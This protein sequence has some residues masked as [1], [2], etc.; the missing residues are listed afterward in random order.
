MLRMEDIWP[1]D[2]AFV[3]ETLVPPGGDAERV[4]RV[5]REQADFLEALLDDPRLY[6]RLR[7]EERLVT[8]SPYL[9][10]HVIL[11]QVRRDV[12]R[13]PHVRE[14][15]DEGERVPVF[16]VEP[17]RAV[18]SDEAL[19]DYVVDLL[20]SYTKV[21]SG[22]VWY[23]EAGRL[24]RLRYSELDIPS[25]RRLAALVPPAERPTV[26]RRVGDGSLFLAGVFPDHVAGGR[27]RRRTGMTLTSLE[28]EAHEAYQQAAR[29][30]TRL[31]QGGA[32]TLERVAAH[33][34]TLRRLLNVVAD[35][36]LREHRAHWFEG[37]RASS[38]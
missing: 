19:R 31:G 6:Q 33:V 11:R 4:A 15:T 7:E 1:S 3:V 25:L 9:V 38:E 28:H 30:A 29:L 37:P 2:I 24:R 23:R 34:P 18:L 20:T 12:D 21:A 22:A 35:G 26:L 10:F 36:Y 5:A 16:G 14:W 17:L 27:A 13:S 8:L 32:R